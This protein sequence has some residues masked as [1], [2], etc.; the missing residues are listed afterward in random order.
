VF[1]NR[2]LRKAFGHRAEEVIGGWRKLLY[3]NLHDF[4]Y[5]PYITRKIKPE[6]VR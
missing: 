5:S 2:M 4:Y 6:M 1:K 3:K